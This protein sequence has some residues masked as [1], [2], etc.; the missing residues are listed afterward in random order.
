MHAD[1]NR[2]ATPDFASLLQPLTHHQNPAAVLADPELESYEKRAI[3]SSWASDFYAVESTPWLRKV[4]GLHN[5]I[6]LSDILSALRA[7]DDDDP[8][9]RGGKAMRIAGSRVQHEPAFG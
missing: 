7:L 6:R 1:Q 9:P 4:R 5:E 3:L 8:P 2:A